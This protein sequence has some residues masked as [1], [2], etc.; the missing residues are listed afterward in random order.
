MLRA[1]DSQAKRLQHVESE[2]HVGVP[3]EPGEAPGLMVGACFWLQQAPTARSQTEAQGQKWRLPLTIVNLLRAFD[4]TT[5]RSSHG[6]C[7]C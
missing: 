7:E 4:P 6:H 2:D 3:E 5:R 1:A